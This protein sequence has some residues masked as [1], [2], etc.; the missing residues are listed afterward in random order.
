MMNF[1]N[2]FKCLKNLKLVVI[3]PHILRNRQFSLIS[4]KQ[5]NE[6]SN[7]DK[8]LATKPPIITENNEKP[9]KPSYSEYKKNQ[10]PITKLMRVKDYADWIFVIF[11]VTGIVIWYKKQKAK[12]E[13]EKKFDVEWLSIPHFKPKIFTCSG[14]YLPD[15]VV[16]QLPDFKEFKKRKDDVWIVSFPKSGFLYL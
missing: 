9:K 4:V 3:K 1:S 12:K 11:L 15:F 5:Q 13:T 2:K 16:K 8:N 6:S 10:S 14:F 7:S